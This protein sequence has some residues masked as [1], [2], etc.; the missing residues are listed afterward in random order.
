MTEQERIAFEKEVREKVAEEQR[1]KQRAYK[2]VW[3]EKNRENI[4][5]Y[6]KD[7]CMRRKSK[8]EVKHNE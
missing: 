2:A 6:N 3:R 4:R 8:E 5:Q 1:A 7:W